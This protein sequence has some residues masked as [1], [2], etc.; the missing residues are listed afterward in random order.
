MTPRLW[1]KCGFNVCTKNF[2]LQPALFLNEQTCT[3]SKQ[4]TLCPSDDSKQNMDTSVTLSHPDDLWSALWQLT[5]LFSCP[6]VQHTFAG[7]TGPANYRW[8]DSKTCH[9]DIH[10]KWRR[11]N[12]AKL[13]QKPHICTH[14]LHKTSQW[15]QP[16]V[17]TNKVCKDNLFVSTNEGTALRTGWLIIYPASFM[18]LI[19]FSPSLFTFHSKSEVNLH[20]VLITLGSQQPLSLP[21]NPHT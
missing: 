15:H 21:S 10:D 5:C 4:A 7:S 16:A 6:S 13:W 17:L 3:L 2:V 1:L 14:S 9:W 8:Q 19:N 11:D 18:A 12:T 20:L